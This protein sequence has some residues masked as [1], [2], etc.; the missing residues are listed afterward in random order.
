ME[1]HERA[2]IIVGVWKALLRG[3]RTAALL[4]WY[5]PWRCKTELGLCCDNMFRCSK[6]QGLS[7]LVIRLDVALCVE[8]FAIGGVRGSSYPGAISDS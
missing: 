6:Y 3:Y 7:G 4:L 8:Y 5:E 2:L 1:W